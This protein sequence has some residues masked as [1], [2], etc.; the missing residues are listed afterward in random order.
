M[1]TQVQQP[2]VISEGDA[3]EGVAGA[4]DVGVRTT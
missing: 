3:V 2:G 4:R 1:W